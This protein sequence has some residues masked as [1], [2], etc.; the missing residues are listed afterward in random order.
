MYL[1]FDALVC[2]V[3]EHGFDRCETGTAG[4]HD[5]RLA[6]I[7]VALEGAERAFEAQDVAFLQYLG[8]HP[9]RVG[10][11]RQADLQLHRAC[12][13]RRIGERERTP[14]A[15]LEHQF[16]VLPGTKIKSLGCWQLER[17][18]NHV[19]RDSFDRGDAR[20]HGLDHDVAETGDF[21]NFNRHIRAWLGNAEQGKAGGTFVVG[22]RERVFVLTLQLSA[23]QF[24]LA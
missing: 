22:E 4:N 1:A 24:A 19:R 10:I 14:F 20:G 9:R 12:F 21:G 8:E 7:G 13:V 15:V 11:F 18:Q 17:D 3:V 6:R 16:D 2:H 23:Q 5:H